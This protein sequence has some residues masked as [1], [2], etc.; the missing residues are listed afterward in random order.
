M[1]FAGRVAVV[2]GGSQGLGRAVAERL[3]DEGAAGVLIVG[4]DEAKG[5]A[6]AAGM[7]TSEARV[8]FISADLSAADAPAAIAARCDELF[9]TCHAL[10]NAAAKTD[11]GSVWDADAELWDEMYST[12]LRSPAL[13]TSAL[14]KLM[15]RDGV[16]GSIVHVGSVAGWGGQPEL[17][18]YSATKGALQALTKNTA[19]ALSRHRIR[20]N[21][22]QP[23]WMNT[24]AE[25]QIQRHYHGAEDGW[26]EAASVQQ[27]F[28]RLID[29]AELARTI[30]F[31]ASDEAGLMTGAIIDYDQTVL[32]PFMARADLEPVWGEDQ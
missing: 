29:P 24:P 18:A 3:V 22:V 17:M 13:L 15:V 16:A 12:N 25:D 7:S 28:G 11:R 14:A 21:L 9:G 27:P 6:A 23:G 4:R 10:V 26:L 31:L 2:T 32:G 19:F 20:V 5:L 30:A 8:A 1:T